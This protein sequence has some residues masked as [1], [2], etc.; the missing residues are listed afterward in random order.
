ML[1]YLRQLDKVSN[2]MIISSMLQMNDKNGIKE[3]EGEGCAFF[4]NND[5]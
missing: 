4:I 3:T 5:D 2:E 1:N